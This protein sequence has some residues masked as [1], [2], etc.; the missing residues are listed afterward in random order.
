MSKEVQV[1][2]AGGRTTNRRRNLD[3][4]FVVERKRVAAYVR[5]IWEYTKKNRGEICGSA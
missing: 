2:K 1:I 3:S 4:G 5:V